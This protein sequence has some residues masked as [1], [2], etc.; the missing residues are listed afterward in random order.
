MFTR[1]ANAIAREIDAILVGISVN[2]L[3]PTTC[4]ATDLVR[5]SGPVGWHKSH[6]AATAPPWLPRRAR[7]GHRTER[8]LAGSRV[9]HWRCAQHRSCGGPRLRWAKS[10][11]ATGALHTHDRGCPRRSGVGADCLEKGVGVTGEESLQG[12]NH[13]GLAALAAGVPRWSLAKRDD[14]VPVY[15]V[16]PL[17]SIRRRSQVHPKGVPR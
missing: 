14:L 17:T 5:L 15:E 12:R 13:D 11:P 16:S 6:F 4:S 3:P 10:R 9:R 8:P 7:V 2:P 1:R